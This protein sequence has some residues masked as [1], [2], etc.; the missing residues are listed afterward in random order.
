MLDAPSG[1]AVWSCTVYLAVGT[2]A[3]FKFCAAVENWSQQWGALDY[4]RAVI[5]LDSADYKSTSGR[6][7]NSNFFFTVPDSGEYVFIFNETRMGVRV[8]RKF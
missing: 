3:Q 7:S 4:M 1:E 6:K 8:M 5:P 2:T